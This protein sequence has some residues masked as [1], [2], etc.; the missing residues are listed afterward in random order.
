MALKVCEINKIKIHQIIYTRFPTVDTNQ[1][2]TSV[3]IQFPITLNI[4]HAKLR[5]EFS[6]L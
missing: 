5:K 4:V 3:V 1:H 2:K 6:V